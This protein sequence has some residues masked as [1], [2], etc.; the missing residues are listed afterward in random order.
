MG[1][2]TIN[3]P[4]DFKAAVQNIVRQTFPAAVPSPTVQEITEKQY[5]G[6]SG[7]VTTRIEGSK[8]ERFT[9]GSSRIGGSY[10]LG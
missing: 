1:R 5:Y 6:I 8:R 3:R 4:P 2:F 10:L 9:W 7:T